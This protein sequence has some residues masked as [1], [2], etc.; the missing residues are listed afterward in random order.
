MILKAFNS[1]EIYQPNWIISD[2]LR[3]FFGFE[4]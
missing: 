2:E 4:I 3:A 1:D